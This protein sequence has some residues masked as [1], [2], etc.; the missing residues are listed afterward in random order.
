MTMI[1]NSNPEPDGGV[2][3]GWF[4]HHRRNR[5]FSG[6]RKVFSA[7]NAMRADMR[8]LVLMIAFAFAFSVAGVRFAFLSVGAYAV[9]SNGWTAEK[10]PGTRRGD[11]VDRNGVLLATNFPV[12][13]LYAHP[14]Q[15]LDA[16]QTVHRLAD[17]FP[18]IETEAL[19]EKMEGKNFVWIKRRISREQ[20]LMVNDIGDPGLLVGYR[21]ARIYPKQ[22]LAAHVLGGVSYGEEHVDAAELKGIAGIE[23]G[24]NDELVEGAQTGKPLQL[25]IDT[26]VQKIVEQVLEGSVINYNAKGGAAVLMDTLTGEIVAMASY[27]TFDPN[28]RNEYLEKINEADSPLFSR[29]FQGIYE[30]GSVFKI[31]GAALALELGLVTP[32]TVMNNRPVSIGKYTFRDSYQSSNGDSMTLTMAVAKSSN[33]ISIRLTSMIG[34]ERQREFLR[35]LGLFDPSPIET[36]EASTAIPV[37]PLGRWS[38][39]TAATIGYGHGISVSVVQLAA[40]Y[41]PLINGGNYVEPTLLKNDGSPV[42]KRRVISPK[43]S[44]EVREMLHKVVTDGTGSLAQNDSYTV[45]GKTGSGEK[46]TGRGYSKDKVIATF[47]SF[48]PVDNPRFVLVVSFDE[49]EIKY[50]NRTRRTAGWIAVPAANLMIQRI[51]PILDIPPA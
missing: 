10:S 7:G 11:I 19:L 50:H 35:S 23:Q 17:I 44:E 20:S 42:R 36:A 25:S 14:P 26:T 6:V 5:I 31:F 3:Q 38:D 45:G 43:T 40:A 30:L 34:E 15:L 37:F 46:A 48:F 49:A 13:S 21:D 8:L 9:E 47:S 16:R 28:R 29:A 33:P 18:D 4:K 51:G 27:P 1:L 41:A 32:E 2:G 12:N 39:L 24:L 22:S